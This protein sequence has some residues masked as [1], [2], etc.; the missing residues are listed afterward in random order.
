MNREEQHYLGDDEEWLFQYCLEKVKEKPEVDY[1]IFGH[2]HLCIER[3]VN[4]KTTYIN[5]GEWIYNCSYLVFDGKGCVLH[6]FE[7]DDP[8]VFH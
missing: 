8:V 3:K 1:F 2:R 5:L 4:E 6:F 7:N